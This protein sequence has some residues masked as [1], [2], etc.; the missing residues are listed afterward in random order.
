M[1]SSEPAPPPNTQSSARRPPTNQSVRRC[2]ACLNIKML[3]ILTSL[4]IAAAAPRQAPAGENKREVTRPVNPSLLG[5]MIL[6][7][8][9]CSVASPAASAASP[10][11]S[12]ILSDVQNVSERKMRVLIEFPLNK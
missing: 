7:P 4:S 8:P 1:W 12:V 5:H 6:S 2:A 11:L 3:A 10:L 9:R